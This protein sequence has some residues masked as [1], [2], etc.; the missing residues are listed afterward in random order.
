MKTSLACIPC[1][2]RQS[3]D[4]VGLCD[5][6]A[7]T[8][9]QFIREILLAATSLDFSQPP[10]RLAGELQSQLRAITGCDDPYQQIKRRYNQLALELLPPLAR[11]VTQNA[12]P[13]GAAVRLAIAGNVIDLGAKSRL[14]EAEV[15]TVVAT[16]LDHPL[17][18]ELE[19]LRAAAGRARRILYLA[20]NAGEIVLDHVLIGLLPRG[21]VTVAVR[22]RSVL[23]DAT[24]EDAIAADLA[25]VSEVIDNGSSVPG[26]VLADCTP[27]FRRRFAEAD[28]VI[29]KGQG[30]FETL[31]QVDAPLFCLF[32]V[33]CDIV[34]A[35]CGHPVGSHV[36]WQAPASPAPT[37][38]L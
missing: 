33:K 38:R 10:P 21:R 30:N 22:G 15:H 36:V 27:E 28:L 37:R 17:V 7:E 9:Q 16:A 3:V 18:G 32:R 24:R 20:D 26:T 35:D 25:A 13:F 14:T 5:A 8:S 34:A 12:D 1:L 4:A 31:H 29:A 6:A 23:N 2:L 11:A 19:S